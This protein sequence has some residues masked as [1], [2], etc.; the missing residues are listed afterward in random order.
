MNRNLI[1]TKLGIRI[2]KNGGY[3]NDHLP[4]FL[5]EDAVSHIRSF[6]ETVP[7]YRATP[8]V[9]LDGLAAKLGV[10]RV[11]VKDESKRFGLNA[12]KGLGGEIG[13][14]SCRERV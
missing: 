8:L 9:R 7:G 4:E 12:F 14:A 1:E 5:K 13:R 2:L 10:K 11:Y 6:H 3:T